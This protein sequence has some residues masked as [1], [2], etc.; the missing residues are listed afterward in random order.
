M[1]GHYPV[2]L[3]EVLESLNPVDGGVYV[4]GTFGAGGYT[5]AI[6]EAAHCNVI[7]ID[8]D[9]DAKM[10]A[11]ELQKKYGE[12]L[13]FLHGCFGDVAALLAVAGIGKVDGFVLDVGVSSFQIDQADRGF[14]FRA[15]GPLDMRMDHGGN[16]ETAA[17][18]VNTYDEKELANLIYLYGDERHSRRIAKKIVERR[19][20]KTFETT[21][22]LAELVATAVPGAGKE[23]I[24]PATRTF[25]ALR[26]AVN[27][28][29]GELERA[30]AASEKILKPDGRL[31]VV[32]FH[33]LEDGAVKSFLKEKSGSEPKGS[34]YLPELPSTMK[35]TFKLEQRKAV[36]P[37]EKEV[38]E[39]LRSRS[40]KLRWAVRT[41]GDA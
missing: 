22:D 13:T 11:E 18:I 19:A 15:D 34:R 26:I 33:S 29:L 23:K 28:E 40:A 24:H 10:R 20:E 2:M 25:Q 16:G 21:L 17:D 5:V 30:L 38:A 31:V 4:D 3:P 36:K 14:S 1:S 39:N 37:S 8:R 7:A 9:P 6:L 32:S 27:D 35:A 12:R 41:E